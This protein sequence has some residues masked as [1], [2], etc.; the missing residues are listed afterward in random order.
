VMPR[1]V[2]LPAPWLYAPPRKRAGHTRSDEGEL[3]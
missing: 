3:I 1:L 2:R